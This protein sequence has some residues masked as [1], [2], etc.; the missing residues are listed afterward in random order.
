MTCCTAIAPIPPEPEP[1][2]RAEQEANVILS[3]VEQ[4]DAALATQAIAERN[5][6]SLL[7]LSIDIQ[8]RYEDV[9]KEN[10]ALRLASIASAAHRK[11]L[12]QLCKD[13]LE[14]MDVAADA[15]E[16][17]AYSSWNHKQL[18]LQH[19]FSELTTQEG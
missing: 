4:R 6:Q 3:Y 9:R 12:E 15:F 10:A 5:F 11:A 1:M 16:S 13:C 17:N 8:T 14:H 2:S 19:R 7:D 18:S